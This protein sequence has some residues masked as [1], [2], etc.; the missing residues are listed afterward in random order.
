[1]IAQSVAQLAATSQLTKSRLIHFGLLAQSLCGRVRAAASLLST[2]LRTVVA[3]AGRR[4]TNWQPAAQ[5]NTGDQTISFSP[6]EEQKIRR[7]KREEKEEEANKS[8]E[9][10]K[11]SP[12]RTIPQG[13]LQVFSQR[14]RSSVFSLRVAKFIGQHK[15]ERCQR[16]AITFADPVD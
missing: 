9:H 16:A 7:S 4:R 11:V 13:D 8:Q 5:S 6:R 10:P 14:S 12:L 2:A 1:M 15:S 3:F